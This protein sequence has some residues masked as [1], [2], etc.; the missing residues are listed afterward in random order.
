[1]FFVRARYPFPFFRYDH[2]I[3]VTQV[4]GDG[5]IGPDL[6]R[7]DWSDGWTT[8]FH[9]EVNSKHYILFLMRDSGLVRIYR[10]GV[11]P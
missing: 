11:D 8:A 1:M 10:V 5:K 3:A 4:L 6:E 2:N 7:Y 9:Y